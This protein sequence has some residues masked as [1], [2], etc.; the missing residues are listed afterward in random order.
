MNSEEKPLEIGPR[1][2]KNRPGSALVV[3]LA[4]LVGCESLI[5]FAGGFYFFTQ[6]FV[7][8]TTNIAGAIVIIVITLLIAFWLAFVGIGT[9]KD[10]AWTKGAIITWQI[11][12][13]ALATSFIAGLSAWQPIGWLLAF[14]ATVTTATFV[15]VIV[16][17]APE[18]KSSS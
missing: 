18:K 10:Q 3:F 17:S 7:Q 9:L 11:L 2:Q 12:Q 6:L 5:V 16:R 4:A 8:K 13:F 14:I 1:S 15:A